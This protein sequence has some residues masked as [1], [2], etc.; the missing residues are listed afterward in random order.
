MTKTR[1][2]ESKVDVRKLWMSQKE[3]MKY[4]GVGKDWL[5]ERRLSGELSYSMIGTTAFFIKSQIDD[6]VRRNAVTGI[7][8][9]QSEK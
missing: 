1:I 9:F 5:K 6:L 8:H 3:A 4:L 7:N 2:K